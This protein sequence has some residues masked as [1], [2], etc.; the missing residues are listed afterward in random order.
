ME[1][2]ESKY[3]TSE[4]TVSQGKDNLE[5]V[6]I[7]RLTVGHNSAEMYIH[8]GDRVILLSP[9]AAKKM[10]NDLKSAVSTWEETNGPIDQYPDGKTKRTESV[11]K[12]ALKTLY[13]SRKISSKLISINTSRKKRFPPRND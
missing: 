9:S 5:T 13:K 3:R 4:S 7:N 6:E 11:A 12:K 1:F 10:V 8:L 2:V